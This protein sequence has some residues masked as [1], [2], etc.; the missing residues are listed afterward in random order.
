M[1]YQIDFSTSLCLVSIALQQYPLSIK[2]FILLFS[3]EATQLNATE[4]H[5]QVWKWTMGAG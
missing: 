1:K 4:P 3:R 2:S 5:D